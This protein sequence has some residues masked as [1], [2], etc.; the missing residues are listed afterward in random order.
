VNN[1]NSPKTVTVNCPVGTRVLG[2]GFSIGGVDNGSVEIT[3]AYPNSN[4]SYTARAT[5]EQLTQ[6]NSNWTITAWAL[7]A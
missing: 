3:Y 1:S 6:T 4:T 5:E 2:G 7:C